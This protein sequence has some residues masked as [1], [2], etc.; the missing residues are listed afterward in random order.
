MSAAVESTE[1]QWKAFYAARAEAVRLS[2]ALNR[3][4][5]AACRKHPLPHVRAEADGYEAAAVRCDR[6]ALELETGVEA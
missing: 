5:A 3:A 4:N 2:A 6:I 1:A